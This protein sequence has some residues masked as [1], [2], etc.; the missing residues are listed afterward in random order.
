MD[1]KRKTPGRIGG[2]SGGRAEH[3]SLESS[4]G[5]E[6]SME[7]LKTELSDPSINTII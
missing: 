2:C 3:S 4:F 7:R 5:I 6:Q 1:G